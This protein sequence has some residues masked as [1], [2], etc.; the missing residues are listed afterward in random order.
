MMSVGLN[1]NA[2]MLVRNAHT[3]IMPELGVE[4]EVTLS[5]G[6]FLKHSKI[7]HTNSNVTFLQTIM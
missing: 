6:F 2:E 4:T 1:R 7:K 3:C 5:Y